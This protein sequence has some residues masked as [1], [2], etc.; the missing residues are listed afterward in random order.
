MTKTEVYSWRVTRHRK[1]ALE[2]EARRSGKSL[3]ALLDDITAQ[4]LL[5]RAE[6]AEGESDRQARLRAEV[7]KVIGT[8]AGGKPRRAE[9]ARA[10]VRQRLT[11]RRAR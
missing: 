5:A 2:D 6:R 4:W 8:I 1:I 10:L 9:Q 3:G 7:A 11:R